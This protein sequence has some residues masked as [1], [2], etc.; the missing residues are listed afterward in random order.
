MHSPAIFATIFLIGGLVAGVVLYV[1]GSVSAE[2]LIGI[3][4]GT[5]LFYLIVGFCC[6]TLTSYLGNID[7]G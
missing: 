3:C 4:V 1:N 6:N 5:Y 7:S 2:A